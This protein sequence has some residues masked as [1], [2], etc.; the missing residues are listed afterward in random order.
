MP[1]PTQMPSELRAVRGGTEPGLAIRAEVAVV[2][3]GHRHAEA[4]LQVSA[5]RHAGQPHVRRYDDV[6]RLRFDHARHGDADG[7]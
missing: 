5:D 3:D 1:V 4:V 2:A 6:A 7:R